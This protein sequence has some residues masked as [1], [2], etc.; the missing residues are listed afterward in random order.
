MP[1]CAGERLGEL[2]RS[3]TIE[4]E[5]LPRLA[6]KPLEQLL[7]WIIRL[8][9]SLEESRHRHVEA[10]LLDVRT[11][12]ERLLKVGLG[13]LTLDRQTMTLSGG[14]SQRMKLAAALDSDLTGVIY[15]LSMIL[16][17]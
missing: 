8:T 17:L 14:E 1:D 7:V 2:S 11:K 6:L 10:Y 5:R 9:D 16:M 13:Y 12:I 3:I 4:G 15:I